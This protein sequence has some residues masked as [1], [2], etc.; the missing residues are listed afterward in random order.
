MLTCV[1]LFLSSFF[2]L[3]PLPLCHLLGS[4]RLS[5]S[6]EIYGLAT[7]DKATKKKVSKKED[8]ASTKKEV[9]AKKKA[10]EKKAEE[11]KAEEKK[12]EAEKQ[13]EADKAQAEREKRDAKEAAQ[14]EKEAK[15]LKAKEAK[16]KAADVKYAANMKAQR[17]KREAESKKAEA[18]RVEDEKIAKANKQKAIEEMIAAKQ[19]SKAKRDEAA[20]KRIKE[21]APVVAKEMAMR[22]KIREKTEEE[23][24][25][26]LARNPGLAKREAVNAYETRLAEHAEKLS[27]VDNFE[28]QYEIHS[29][30]SKAVEDFEEKLSRKK[31]AKSSKKKSIEE[32]PINLVFT[33]VE[34]AESEYKV[35]KRRRAMEKKNEATLKKNQKKSKIVSRADSGKY[36]CAASDQYLL[37]SMGR[38]YEIK[39]G[40]AFKNL[41]KAGQYTKIEFCARDSKAPAKT[42]FAFTRKLSVCKE[43]PKC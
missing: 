40:V 38:R 19:K 14:A 7:K 8:A 13:R 32:R 9:E 33:G 4:H 20:Q 35:I 16:A 10:E 2:S 17:I 43:E 37:F 28:N 23:H 1:S 11:K 39:E 31:S 24:E 12:A 3:L 27:T 30:R 25:A 29:Q 18:K 15:E 36:L 34:E 26:W 21:A 6:K 5:Q 22:K 41:G 42:A